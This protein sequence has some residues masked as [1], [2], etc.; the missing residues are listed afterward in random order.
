MHIN[1]FLIISF[2]TATARISMVNTFFNSTFWR[3]ARVFFSLDPHWGRDKEKGSSDN[4]NSAN[5]ERKPNKTPPD[6]DDIWRDFNN[7]LNNLFKGNKNSSNRNSNGKLPV[8]QSRSPFRGIIIVLVLLVLGWLASGIYIVQEGQS[9]F[10]LRFG[11]FERTSQPGI[12]WRL[13][14]PFETD[15]TVNM[16]QLRSIEIGRE[17]TTRQ[18]N[19]NDASMLTSDENIIDV[20]FAVQYRIKNG[21]DFLFNNVSAEENVAQ[22][23][24]TAVREIVGR[25]KMD[26]VL[27]EDREQVGIDLHKSIQDILDSYGTGILVTSVT[28]HNVQPPRQ[29]QAAFDDAVK[30]G[31]DGERQKNEARAYVNDILPRA[32]GAA[33][34]I[35]AEADAYRSRIL[36]QAQGDANRFESVL[37]EYV[38][39]PGI[40][41]ERMYLETM[42]QIYGRSSKVLVDGRNNNNML[43]LPLDK[44]IA[45]SNQNSIQPVKAASNA[46]SLHQ[47]QTDSSSANMSSSG[48]P[49]NQ[50][51][52]QQP[53]LRNRLGNE[54]RNGPR[55][56][57][58]DVI[59]ELMGNN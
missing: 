23:A 54:Q 3:R 29:V 48:A 2:F 39:A 28:M 52:P 32:H 15:E 45:N 59:G 24:E 47:G 14:F 57:R 34:R 7:R 25:R 13:P 18:S 16:S 40:T 56:P 58:Y 20:R 10:V 55:D 50:L 11:K 30:A 41:R 36:S 21:A 19:L 43:Y 44:L 5:N 46:L 37:A 53:N 27:Y 22:A 1:I 38:K 9:G 8:N 42:Q 4:P 17:N 6:L 33:E 12:Q 35:K 26:S 51:F 31:Q 49:S